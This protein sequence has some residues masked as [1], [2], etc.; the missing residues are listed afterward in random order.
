MEVVVVV[1][2]EVNV[3]EEER[4]FGPHVLSRGLVPPGPT[5]TMGRSPLLPPPRVRQC[6]ALEADVGMDVIWMWMWMWSW[7]WRWR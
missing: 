7:R 1:E 3:E 5:G 6:C 2:G 4:R